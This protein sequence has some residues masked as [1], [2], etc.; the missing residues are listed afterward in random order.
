MLLEHVAASRGG[1]I[2]L[3]QQALQPFFYLVG[4]GCTFRRLREELGWLD[5]RDRFDFDLREWDAPVPI[6]L[7]QPHL[8]GSLR[9]K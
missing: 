4:A 8:I 1:V 2:W 7:M 6:S 3:L 5:L 9:K